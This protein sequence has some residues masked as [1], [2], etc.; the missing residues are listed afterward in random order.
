MCKKIELKYSNFR[1]V[2]IVASWRKNQISNVWLYRAYTIQTRL[3][4]LRKRLNS[5]V[6]YGST[7]AALNEWDGK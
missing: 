1:D 5:C 3:V 6:F 2:I 7:S 4:K